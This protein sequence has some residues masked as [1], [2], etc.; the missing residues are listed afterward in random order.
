MP[1][2][3]VSPDQLKLQQ[4]LQLHDEHH[5][6]LTRVLR[7][8][9]QDTVTICDGQ[10]REYPATVTHIDKKTV[11]LDLGPPVQL[12]A[13]DGPRLVLVQGL[14]KSTKM[15]WVIQ[16]ATEL[17]ADTLMPTV[18][19]RSVPKLSKERANKRLQ[20]WQ[21]IAAAASAQCGRGDVPYITPLQPNLASAL[22]E[23]ETYIDAEAGVEADTDNA[24]AE[25]PTQP[26][27]WSVA[28][29]EDQR[30][31]TLNE[32]IPADLAQKSA[33]SLLIGPEGGLTQHEIARCRTA[34]WQV[35]SLGRLIL[36]AETAA[37]AGL[38]LLSARSGRLG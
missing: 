6:Y 2:L 7:L 10:G 31:C 26:N 28:F 23:V 8:T 38:I 13:F 32:I 4:P 34:G 27:R 33:V 25:P 29:W 24:P 37:L 36:R 35:A 11:T 15:E 14:L 19:H 3:F 1:R 21:K 12:P 18:C 16:K 17:G 20:R 22:A 9:L 30:D 5:N